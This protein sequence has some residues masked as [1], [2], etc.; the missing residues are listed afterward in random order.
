MLT[1]FKRCSEPSE[2]LGSM[3]KQHHRTSCAICAHRCWEVLWAKWVLGLYGEAAPQDKGH[4]GHTCPNQQDEVLYWLK[5]KKIFI[6]TFFYHWF[7]FD[8]RS[9][10]YCLFYCSSGNRDLYN[11]YRSPIMHPDIYIYVSK[12]VL[13]AWKSFKRL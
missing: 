10:Y 4:K 5:D 3:G 8:L 6:Y 9:L 2:S 7:N 12:S 11:I 13:I 1:C